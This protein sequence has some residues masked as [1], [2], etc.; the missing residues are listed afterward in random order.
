MNSFSALG[1]IV[2][3]VLSLTTVLTSQRITALEA[4]VA[5]CGCARTPV[6]K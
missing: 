6:M 5:Q 3:V 4:K 1:C 2:I